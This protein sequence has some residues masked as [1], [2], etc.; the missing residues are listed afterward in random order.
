[1]SDV[2]T[3]AHHLSSYTS[4]QKINSH[5][6]QRRGWPPTCDTRLTGGTRLAR[7]AASACKQRRMRAKYPSLAL[8][9]HLQGMS[10]DSASCDGGS[11]HPPVTPV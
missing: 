5:I 9:T 11:V 10:Q 4:K 6:R 8:I 2:D 1:M 3:T 7:E